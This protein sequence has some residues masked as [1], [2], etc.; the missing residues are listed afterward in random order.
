MTRACGAPR[1]RR[2]G[3]AG[4]ALA[5]LVVGLTG[6]RASAQVVRPGPTRPPRPP[7]S[8]QPPGPVPRGTSAP[9]TTSPSFDLKARFGLDAAK[10]LLL[11]SDPD[12]RLRGAERLASLHV[13]EALAVLVRVAGRAERG[14][15][16]PRAP[17]EGVVRADPRAALAVVRGLAAWGDDEHA[18]EALGDVLELPIATQVGTSVDPAH[19]DALGAGRVRLARHE[20]ALAMARSGRRL[21]LEALLDASRRE[22]AGR[23]AALDALTQVPPEGPLFGGVALTT[24]ETVAL[25]ARVGDLRAMDAL[26]DALGVSDLG[27]RVAAL[28]ALGASGDRRVLPAAR[29]GVKDVDPRVRVAATGA[30]VHLHAPDAAAAV[31][32]LVGDDATAAEGLALAC[33]ARSPGIVKAAAARAVASGDGAVRARAIVALG[34]QTD[35]AA[36]EALLSLSGDPRLGGDAADMLARSP[37]PGALAAI[38]RLAVGTAT[39]R[40]A[41]RAYAVRRATRG[42]RSDRLE[43]LLAAL[44]ASRDALDRAVADETRLPPPPDLSAVPTLELHDR[45]RRD[46]PEGPQ[47]AL[48]LGRRATDD[49]VAALAPLLSSP[50]PLLR[51]HVARGLGSAPARDATG[52]LAAAYDFEPDVDVRR[53]LIDALAARS[54]DADAPARRD[55]LHLAARLDPDPVVRAA[56]SRAEQGQAPLPPLRGHEVAWLRVVPAESASLPPGLRGLLVGPD[57]LAREVAFDAEGYALVPDLPPGP[58]TLRLAPAVGSYE[59]P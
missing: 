32:A 34:R 43:A 58:A 4:G 15:V 31:E 36:L 23:E 54:I 38:E 26:V 20:A 8:V 49:D 30:L 24:P 37:A 45:A 9:A 46:G 19:Q 21:A 42:D 53:A 22:G 33:D 17:I 10:H 41:A 7:S 52:R 1:A 28:E 11:S 3:L 35:G 59:S 40:L 57:G 51:G 14:G 29:E 47:A 16:D 6:A 44:T 2:P 12:E 27:V 56:A 18:L 25:A 50:D 13:P 55:A 48:E 39:R 5:L